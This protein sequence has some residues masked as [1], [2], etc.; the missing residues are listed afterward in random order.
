MHKA[1]AIEPSTK[2]YEEARLRRIVLSIESGRKFRK[3]LKSDDA[4]LP[5][6]EQMADEE[7]SIE[8][9]MV[10]LIEALNTPVSSGKETIAKPVSQIDK[11]IAE[12]KQM[13]TAYFQYDRVVGTSRRI[14]NLPPVGDDPLPAMYR[15]IQKKKEEI[16]ELHEP[17]SLVPS[18]K[19]YEEASARRIVLMIELNT[20]WRREHDSNNAPLSPAEQLAKEE[21]FI[22]LQMVDLTA[23]LNAPQ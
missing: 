4:P 14:A 9:T 22:E 8:L 10:S 18:T 16:I 20:T 6:A 7:M 13:V 11:E 2:L 21:T 12:Y 3:A 19:L 1:L 17:L 15:A 5:P 23:E